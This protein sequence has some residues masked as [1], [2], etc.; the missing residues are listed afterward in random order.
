[1]KTNDL[2]RLMRRIVLFC[3]SL[4]VPLAVSG[5]TITLDVHDE[6]RQKVIMKIQQEYGYSVA[7]NSTDVDLDV[8]V[9]IDVRDEPVE[10]VMEMIFDGENVEC[11]VSGKTIIVSRAGQQ[12]PDTLVTVTGKIVDDKNVPVIGAAVMVKGDSSTGSISDLDG[13]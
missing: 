9:S 5:Q 8:P 10:K 11:R 12:Q 2:N 1:M 13:N 3:F 6:S 7:F 4:A